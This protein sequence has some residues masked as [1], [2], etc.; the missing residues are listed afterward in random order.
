[1]HKEQDLKLEKDFL[2]LYKYNEFKTLVMFMLQEQKKIPAD[3]ELQKVKE[4][5]VNVANL[6]T[7][8]EFEEQIIKKYCQ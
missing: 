6:K 3:L 5:I 4:L 1:M 2:N 7:F 8:A